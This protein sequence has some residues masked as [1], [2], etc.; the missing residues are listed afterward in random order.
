MDRQID[1][2]TAAINLRL[3]VCEYSH[4]YIYIYIYIHTHIHIFV[5]MYCIIFKC[6]SIINLTLAKYVLMFSA[7]FV[8][9]EDANRLLGLVRTSKL[10]RNFRK[11]AARSGRARC[12]HI[13]GTYDWSTD[14]KRRNP[15]IPPEI[16]I[17]A[18]P[19]DI[20]IFYHDYSTEHC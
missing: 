9:S 13:S 11:F 16:Q 20:M 2:E 17:V 19:S 4:V 12:Q 18:D 6:L 7:V 1:G 5:C 10:T 14:Q 3:H 8:S 15:L